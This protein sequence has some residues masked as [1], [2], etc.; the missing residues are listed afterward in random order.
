MTRYQGVNLYVKNLD[1]GIDDERLHKEFSPF[2]TITSAKVMMDGDRSK[3]FGF[4]CFASPE[5]A[6]QAMME[7][8]GRIVDNKPLY[9]SLAQRKE[10]RQE[11]LI[12][13]RRQKVASTC[14]MPSPVHNPFQPAP[15]SEYFTAPIPQVWNRAPY[16]PTSQKA[17]LRPSPRLTTQGFQNMPA[18]MRP[19]TPRPQRGMRPAS[20]MPRMMSTPRAGFQN[21]PANMRPSTPRPQRGMR[22][23]LQMPRMMSTPRAAAQTPGPR[24]PHCKHRARTHKPKQNISAQPQDE[25]VQETSVLDSAEEETNNL[26]KTL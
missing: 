18:N 5:A 7:M 3:C 16:Y 8:N 22:P 9:V 14:A 13:Q 12:N 17:Q 26:P 19:S 10:E 25:Q 4:V 20:Q 24:P 23:A 2:G 21:M 15:L 11:F 1:P 6:H